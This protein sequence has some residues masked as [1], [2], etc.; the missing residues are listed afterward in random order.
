MSTGTFAD[1]GRPASIPRALFHDGIVIVG[2]SLAVACLAQLSVPVPGSPV[3]FTGQT[4]G[5]L[6][7]GAALGSTRGMLCLLLYLGQGLSGLPVFAYGGAGLLHLSGPTGGYLMGFV[8]AAGVVGFLTEHGWDRRVWTT[9]LAMT[10]GTVI[11][12]ASGLTWLWW[13]GANHALELAVYPFLP[14]AGVK[15]LLAGQL[16]P[17]AWWIVGKSS[18]E[19]R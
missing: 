8:V 14:F 13:M 17:L 18:K 10:L 9:L 2:G 15:I 1:F 12:L 16:L 3:P 11:I 7:V 4:L 6:L 5:V 19:V